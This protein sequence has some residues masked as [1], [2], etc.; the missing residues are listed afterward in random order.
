MAELLLA[1]GAARDRLTDGIFLTRDAGEAVGR[2][3]QAIGQADA[4]AQVQRKLRGALKSGVLAAADE[5]LLAQARAAGVLDAE[6]AALLDAWQA[7]L[8]QIIAVDAFPA[9]SLP[10]HGAA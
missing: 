10:R 5:D 9:D 7:Q 8:E 6:E 1:P 4:A 3:E 2:L